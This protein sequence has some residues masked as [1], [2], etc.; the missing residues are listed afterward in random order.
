MPNWCCDRLDRKQ[1]DSERFWVWPRFEPLTLPSP[2]FLIRVSRSLALRSHSQCQCQVLIPSSSACWC[3]KCQHQVTETQDRCPL[4]LGCQTPHLH[5]KTRYVSHIFLFIW[6][7]DILRYTQETVQTLNCQLLLFMGFV[8]KYIESP[9]SFTRTE[10]VSCGLVLWKPSSNIF[11][12][13]YELQH[14]VA[15]DV[16]IERVSEGLIGLKLKLKSVSDL[17]D[18]D[19]GFTRHTIKQIRQKKEKNLCHSIKL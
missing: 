7:E 4:Q 3:G 12:H 6:L 11:Q 15:I 17:G 8:L 1:P 19:V 14:F 5:Y 2:W 16:V 9:L 13:K 18:V 10:E